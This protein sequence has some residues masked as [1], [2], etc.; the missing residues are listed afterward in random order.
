MLLYA[1]GRRGR[2]RPGNGDRIGAATTGAVRNAALAAYN[3]SHDDALAWERYAQAV[4][5][6]PA[7]ARLRYEQD[8]LA[9]RLGHTVQERLARLRPV[10]HLVLTRDDLTIASSGSWSRRVRAERADEILRT[11]RFHPWE[12]ARG[13][14]VAA[15]DATLRRARAAAGGPAD[16]PGGGPAAV[17]RTRRRP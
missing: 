5:L 9:D 11:R 4:A 13:R 6:A 12:G 17:R 8:Q 2:R 14:V 15:W 10:E 1:H 7:D 16:Q 3:I